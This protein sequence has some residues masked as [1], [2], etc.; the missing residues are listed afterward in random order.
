MDD[1]IGDPEHIF[2]D[3]SMV[4]RTDEPTSIIAL[5]LK[6]VAISGILPSSLICFLVHH[7]I[8]TC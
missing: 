7:N 5:A 6:S 2:R 8:E 4:V 1:L 3:S